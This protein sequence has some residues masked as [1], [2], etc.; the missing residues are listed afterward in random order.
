MEHNITDKK[1]VADK[2]NSQDSLPD[3][4]ISETRV[5]YGSSWAGK[6]HVPGERI[7]AVLPHLVNTAREVEE[8][9]SDKSDTESNSG[10][11]KVGKSSWLTVCFLALFMSPNC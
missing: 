10:E 11:I 9:K 1:S 3:G 7:C 4:S 2:K 8:R 6:D 5:E